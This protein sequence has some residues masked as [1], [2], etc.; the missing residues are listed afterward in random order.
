MSIILRFVNPWTMAE[1]VLDEAAAPGD[2]EAESD[3][4]LTQ[5]ME[6][7]ALTQP[8]P[9]SREEED[10]EL[11]QPM[12]SQATTISP[13]SYAMDRY[14]ITSNVLDAEGGDRFLLTSDRLK[15]RDLSVE[16]CYPEPGT[17]LSLHLQ[18]VGQMALD[19]IESAP[20]DHLDFMRNCRDGRMMQVAE[21][22]LKWPDCDTSKGSPFRLQLHFRIAYVDEEGEETES[23]VSAG[24]IRA[25][26]FSEE[27]E[28]TEHWI[29]IMKGGKK[30]ALWV[31]VYHTNLRRTRYDRDERDLAHGLFKIKD[32][33]KIDAKIWGYLWNFER[34]IR[35]ESSAA[36]PHGS[37][38]PS[39]STSSLPQVVS[40]A[41]ASKVMNLIEYGFAL[42]SIC[43]SYGRP[44]HQDAVQFM[45]YHKQ[46]KRMY[47]KAAMQDEELR[48]TLSQLDVVYHM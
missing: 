5:P 46:V 23:I 18:Q 20:I 12:P 37:V 13:E 39:S 30:G 31:S 9:S 19:E 15:A 40:F 24:Q 14:G 38:P 11:T 32:A 7:I 2:S 34:W 27:F 26:T 35:S 28:F 29:R 3:I 4:V 10:A 1:Y 36:R 8:M 44:I 25:R 42:E 47:V 16:F 48:N 6:E 43:D 22:R 41:G 33:V 45:S 17:N 21:V